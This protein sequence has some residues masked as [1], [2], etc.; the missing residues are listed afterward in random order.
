MDALRTTIREFRALTPL[1]RFRREVLHGL[2][3]DPRTLPCKYFYDE[4]GSEL[5][6]RICNLPEYYITRTELAVMRRHAAEMAALIGENARIIE[7][8]SGS[9]QKTQVLLDHARCPAAY[10]PVD[11]SP[12]PLRES[13]PRLSA[14]YWGLE[15]LPVCADFTQ[16]FY[17]PRPVRTPRRTV[18]YFPGSTIGN[19]SPRRTERLLRR[20]ARL[21]G[22]LGG[23]VI[24]V[25]L[26]KPASIL[27][28]A[29]ND[30]SGVTREFNLNLL[31][32][33]NRELDA[34]FDLSLFLHRAV[35]N[36]AAG[37]IEMHLI[38]R[39]PQSVQVGECSFELARGS[40]IRTECSYKYE[41]AAFALLARRAGW[42][43]RRVWT[44][45]QNWFGVLYLSSEHT[46]PS[47][48]SRQQCAR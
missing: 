34:D 30:A 44:D 13:L 2:R 15:I 46:V 5:F 18:I 14:R 19:F 40:R 23:L 16:R 39:R 38:S 4:R 41:V 9:S 10:V 17:P 22:S 27:E 48:A 33:I 36:E 31:A 32:R 28:P 20:M 24:G 37:R 26:R 25:D 3:S 42:Q 12:V 1:E 35:Y 6:E 43:L 45:E 7:F 29:Y 8:G 21:A 11:I 47:S